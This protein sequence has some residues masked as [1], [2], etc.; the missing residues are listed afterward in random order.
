MS[1]QIQVSDGGVAV[2]LGGWDL[3]MNWRRR[4]EITQ[5]QIEAARIATRSLLEQ[6]I[7]HRAIGCGTHNGA[8][9]PNE[10]RTGTMLGRD[11][12]GKQLWMVEAGPGDRPLVVLDLAD[13]EYK[14]AVL[15]VADPERFLAT[16]TASQPG[17]APGAESG[18]NP[19]SE[20]REL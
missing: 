10:R 17:S 3:A 20:P 7:D 14:R 1:F 11:V 4:I 6:K 18:S 5:Q 9:R 16:L 13:H 2:E 12:D 19:D 8:E 15:E